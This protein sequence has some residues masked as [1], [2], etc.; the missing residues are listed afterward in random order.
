MCAHKLHT[1]A[2]ANIAED[3]YFVYTLCTE[4]QKKKPNFSGFS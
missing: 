3:Y 1:C 2:R 4:R